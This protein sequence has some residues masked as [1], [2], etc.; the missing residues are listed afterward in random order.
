MQTV[1]AE[2]PREF[3][4]IKIQIGADWHI[5]DVFCKMDDQFADIFQPPNTILCYQ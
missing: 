1:K 5:G 4:T 3:D 2:L